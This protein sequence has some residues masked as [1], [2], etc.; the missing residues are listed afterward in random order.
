M[1]CQHDPQQLS[2]YLDGELAEERQRLVALRMA[3]CAT[4][5]DRLEELS[6][7]SRTL[8]IPAVADPSFIVRVRNAREQA[9]L[10]FG[11]WRRLA[12][13]LVPV[14]ILVLLAAGLLIWGS[15]GLSGAGAYAALERFE[16]GD[17]LILESPDGLAIEESVLRIAVEPFELEP[18][19]MDAPSPT[20][21][22]AQERL[23]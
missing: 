17:E 7:L 23:R 6:E 20:G 15:T 9:S 10:S 18:T 3:E 21:G 1:N 19:P 11:M 22:D 12:I 14:A 5:R 8:S 4:C 16:I 2:A 13:G